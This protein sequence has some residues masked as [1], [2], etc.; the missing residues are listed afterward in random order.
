MFERKRTL[1]AFLD[2]SAAYDNVKRNILV[3]EQGCFNKLLRFINKWIREK[4]NMYP[5]MK[6]Y[7]QSVYPEIMRKN[8]GTKKET[9]TGKSLK[10]FIICTVY[11]K[12]KELQ[13]R[14]QVLQFA[15]DITVYSVDKGDEEQITFRRG[16]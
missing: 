3:E 7:T 11:K 14:I 13:A 8:S 10:S 2:V 4:L 12:Y 9:P 1:A 6:V 15:N 16:S 5:E